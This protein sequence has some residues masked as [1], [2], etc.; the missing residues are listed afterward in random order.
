MRDRRVALGAVAALAAVLAACAPQVAA[1]PEAGALAPS[2]FPASH[3]QRLLAQGTPV[4]RVDAARSIVVVEVRRGGSLARFGHDHVVASHDA[5]GYVAPDEGRADL[6]L[7]LA[8]LVVDEPALRAEAGFDTQ[9]SPADIAGTR[10]NM[11]DKVLE[12]DRYPHALIAVRETGAD[13]STGR[14]RVTVTLHGV[15]RPVEVA[16]RIAVAADGVAV[17]GTASIDQSEF[18][19]APFSILGGAIAVQDRVNVSFR[20]HARRI[21]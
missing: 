11:L 10:S 6:Y 8:A 19:I 21:E 1:P 16:A 9:P 7:P 4:F 12:V 18:G 13:G 5:A 2:D 3:Y 14:F 20:I 15:S 17:T